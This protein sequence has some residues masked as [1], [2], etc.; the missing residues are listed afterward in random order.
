[1]DDIIDSLII[2]GKEKYELLSII[3]KNIYNGRIVSS[4]KN[5]IIK[6]LTIGSNTSKSDM[7]KI[8]NETSIINKIINTNISHPN[9]VKYIDLIE[10]FDN[11]YIIMEYAGK[12]TLENIINKK[13]NEDKLKIYI[14]QIL[15][16]LIFLSSL[17]YV[18]GDLKPA[19]IILSDDSENIKICDLGFCKKI[20]SKTDFIQGSPLYMAPEL[21]SNNNISD[22]CDIWS[23]GIIIVE[24]LYGHQPFFKCKDINDLKTTISNNELI[25]S[26]IEKI[27]ISDNLKDL[28][29][30]ILIK[31][32]SKRINLNDILNHNWLNSITS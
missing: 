28:L 9:I 23:L 1:M 20:N 2:E 7:M 32:T 16:G 6:V 5:V 31:E 11:T 4:G 30:K 21:F 26:I 8:V 22:Y 17:N 24:M 15:N 25:Y 3:N 19:N 18:H 29:N 13:I 14:K 10:T 12:N 27:N